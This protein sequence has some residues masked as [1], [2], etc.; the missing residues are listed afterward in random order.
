MT[1]TSRPERA[2]PVAPAGPRR[3]ADYV[4]SEAAA[5]EED[6]GASLDTR[7]DAPEHLP[8]VPPDGNVPADPRRALA[9]RP[10]GEPPERV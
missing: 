7:P 4:P 3:P 10:S 6:P 2:S 8:A 1:D 9:E 5:G